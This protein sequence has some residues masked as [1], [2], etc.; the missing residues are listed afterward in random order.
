MQ[1]WNL[2]HFCYTILFPYSVPW[3]EYPQIMTIIA[4]WW[5]LYWYTT[6]DR[7]A[8]E[9]GMPMSTH[10]LIGNFRDYTAI[11][12]PNFHQIWDF[13]IFTFR[14][15]CVSL[16]LDNILHHLP[17]FKY[18]LALTYD[19]WVIFPPLMI[20]AKRQYKRNSLYTQHIGNLSL[21]CSVIHCAHWLN[22]CPL[23]PSHHIWP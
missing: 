8:D 14:I 19:V 5:T 1:N 20:M 21:I 9:V 4:A 2:H 16:N 17:P 23:L 12:A 11:D 13:C 15:V 7:P 10:N 22:K 6:I 3:E 18:K